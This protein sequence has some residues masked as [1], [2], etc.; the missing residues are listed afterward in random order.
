MSLVFCFRFM[1]WAVFVI[2]ALSELKRRFKQGG[3]DI[4][5]FPHRVLPSFPWRLLL[6]IPSVLT[7]EFSEEMH[8]CSFSAEQCRRFGE[9]IQTKV[10]TTL[11]AF[12]LGVVSVAADVISFFIY[13]PPD[14]DSL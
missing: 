11:F 1:V 7:H 6:N 3:D 5:A 8:R 9:S 13:I 2:F 10:L 4:V 12:G 14:R